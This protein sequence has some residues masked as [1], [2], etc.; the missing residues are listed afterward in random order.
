MET[1]SARSDLEVLIYLAGVD[2]VRERSKYWIEKKTGL[3]RQT[4]YDAIR[5]LRRGGLISERFARKSRA[6]KPIRYYYP[7]EAG[8][9]KL[10]QIPDLSD[11]IQ[12]KLKGGRLRYFYGLR[13]KTDIENRQRTRKTVEV[14]QGILETERREG[15][16]PNSV[17][18]LVIAV[19]RKGRVQFGV[20]SSSPNLIDRMLKWVRDRSQNQKRD[21]RRSSHP[22]R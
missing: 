12:R 4:T 17:L 22:L 7:S 1:S 5:R 10:A 11:S 14:F 9:M 3:A 18:L 15:A 2:A 21:Y 16:P 13:E 6:G 19:D 8:W 20:R